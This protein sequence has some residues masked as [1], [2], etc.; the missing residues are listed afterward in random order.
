MML[1]ITPRQYQLQVW[2]DEQQDWVVGGEWWPTLGRVAVD[3]LHASDA[4]K[5]CQI[6]SRDSPS[7]IVIQEAEPP[8]EYSQLWDGIIAYSDALAELAAEGNS[9]EFHEEAEAK[10][11]EKVMLAAR[12]EL[13]D[14]FA[15]ATEWMPHLDESTEKWTLKPLT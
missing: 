3:A 14:A 11:L 9:G 5:R 6:V 1:N 10:K 15:E 7:P 8:P 4:G 13:C 2:S 12:T